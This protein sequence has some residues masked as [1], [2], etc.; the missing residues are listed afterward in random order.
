MMPPSRYL[1]LDLFGEPGLHDERFGEP[2]TAGVA[3]ANESGLHDYR[4]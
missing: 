2:N 4:P 3:N 1:K